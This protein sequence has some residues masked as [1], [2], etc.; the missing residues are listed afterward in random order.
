MSKPIK[1]NAPSLEI[2]RS[3]AQ[4]QARRP[5][6]APVEKFCAVIVPVPPPEPV[7][8][9]HPPTPP[10]PPL[11]ACSLCSSEPTLLKGL[12]NL[13][14]LT[15]PLGFLAVGGPVLSLYL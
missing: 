11:S 2:A 3:T 8:P 6:P 5:A 15:F 9:E 7:I 1:S 14:F 13:A 10:A 12:L 4:R